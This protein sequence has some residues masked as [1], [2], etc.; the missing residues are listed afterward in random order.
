MGEGPSDGWWQG[1]FDLGRGWGWSRCWG[2][3]GLRVGGLL[4][5]GGLGFATWFG[6]EVFDRNNQDSD[7]GEDGD[8]CS[9]FHGG[10]NK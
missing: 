5:W 9:D 6:P 1:D 10:G 7:E 2:R 3:L 8:R 4:G